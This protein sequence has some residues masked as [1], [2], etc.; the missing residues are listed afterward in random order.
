MSQMEE[1]Q[2]DLDLKDSPP[3]KIW[4]LLNIIFSKIFPKTG[5]REMGR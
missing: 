5:R 4:I 3:K 2:I 1:S